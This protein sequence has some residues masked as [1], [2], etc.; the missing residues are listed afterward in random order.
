MKKRDIKGS[1][2][3]T[4]LFCSILFIFILVQFINKTNSC[5]TNEI[6][7]AI[8]G[9][10]GDIIGGLIGTILALLGTVLLIAT[11]FYQIK[12]SKE[13]EIENRF[14][15]LLL[16]HRENVNEITNKRKF[17]KHSIE[18]FW[19]IRKYVDECYDNL[20][21]EITIAEEDEWQFS[22]FERSNIAYLILFF[23]TNLTQN[24]TLKERICAMSNCSELITNV[25]D[26]I[27]TVNIPS[28][29]SIDL[30]D[31]I[32]YAIGHYYRHLYQTINYINDCKKILN[33][34]KKYFY[35]KTLRAQLSTYE[36]MLFYINSISRLGEVWEL[37]QENENKKLITKYNLIKN[38]PLGCMNDIEPNLKYN[39]VQYESLYFYEYE[40]IE[41]SRKKINYC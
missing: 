33:Y 39:L 4:T 22:E 11:L 5:K 18:T 34:K 3:V 36:Q 24:D 13:Q 7:P 10:F 14:I 23:G 32:Q 30:T 19:K 28:N 17:F 9:Q 1:F 41:I 37:L 16:I 12:S 35:V 38:I 15:Q 29:E 6:D 8:W 31:G 26:K 2:Y 40:E 27:D 20:K 25:L 21:N